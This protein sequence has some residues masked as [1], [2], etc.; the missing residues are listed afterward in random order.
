MLGNNITDRKNL[1]M[2]YTSTGLPD[3][4]LATGVS[5][6]GKHRPDF[7]LSRRQIKLGLS[8]IF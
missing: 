5:D 6:E 3:Q 7:Y 2:V 4:T 8:V 1:R